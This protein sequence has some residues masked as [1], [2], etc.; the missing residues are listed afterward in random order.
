M[1]SFVVI[2]DDDG[3]GTETAAHYDVQVRV[4]QLVTLDGTREIARDRLDHDPQDGWEGL[5]GQLAVQQRLADVAPED[6]ALLLAHAKQALAEWL[7]SAQR[8]SS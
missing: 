1:A 6:R 8:R 7:A 5:V 2:F 3:T 4:G